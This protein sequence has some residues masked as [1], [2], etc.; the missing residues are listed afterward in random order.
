M[1][2]EV[3]PIHDRVNRVFRAA[4]ED[5]AVTRDRI[6]QAVFASREIYIVAHSEGTVVSWRSLMLAA[7]AQPQ[8]AWLKEVQGFVTLGSPIDKHHLFW[9]QNFPRD[10]PTE[11]NDKIR[12][13]NFWDY[14]DPVGHSL[15][16]IFGAAAKNNQFERVYDAGF[17][18]YPVPGVAHVDYWQDP[19][20]YHRIIQEVMGVPSSYTERQLKTDSLWWGHWWFMSL[21]ERIVYGLGRT[22]EILAMVYFLSRLLSVVRER[23]LNHFSGLEAW[24]DFVLKWPVPGGKVIGAHW[25]NLALWVAGPALVWKLIWDGILS[26]FQARNLTLKGQFRVE[27]FVGFIFAGILVLAALDL[28]PIQPFASDRPGLKD[29]TGWA[30]GLVISILVWKLHTVVAKGLVQLWRY[31]KGGEPFTPPKPVPAPAHNEA[32]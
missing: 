6:P 3:D 10:V 20:I 26:R 2:A 8:P 17:A 29:Y 30:A 24:L 14:S 27:R 5:I 11:Q 9:N 21:G 31:G 22:V 18:R 23:L 4:L 25:I 32:A 1:Y 15:E 19:N 28:P 7:A 16:G 13:W 12:W